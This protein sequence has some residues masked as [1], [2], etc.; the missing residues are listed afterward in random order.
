M[1]GVS[2]KP[3]QKTTAYSADTRLRL[4]PLERQPHPNNT[5]QRRNPIMAGAFGK[6]APT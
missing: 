4:A 1:K 3:A 5:L 2:Q 6:A